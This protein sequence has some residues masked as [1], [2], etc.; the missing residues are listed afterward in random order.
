[1]GELT[2][3]L[4]FEV[5]PDA[6]LCEGELVRDENGEPTFEPTAFVNEAGE[7]ES[8]FVCE[9]FEDATDDNIAET[10]VQIFEGGGLVTTGCSRWQLGP[11]RNCGFSGGFDPI[12]C[13]PGETVTV[14]CSGVNTGSAAAI[15]IY[16]NSALL[17]P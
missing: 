3:T 5:N 15:H 11:T 13:T 17:N 6:F 2:A 1:M 7:V 4:A 12:A 10:E 9:P 8:R 16:K 14:R